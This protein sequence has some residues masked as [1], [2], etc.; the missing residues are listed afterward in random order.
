M[1]DPRLTVRLFGLRWGMRTSG[2]VVLAVAIGGVISRLVEIETEEASRGNGWLFVAAPTIAVLLLLL[3]GHEALKLQIWHRQGVVINRI[4]L[5]LFGGFSDLSG[6]AWTPRRE[7]TGA[8]TAFLALA[9]TATVLAGGAYLARNS[10]LWLRVPLKT[11]AIAAVGLAVLQTL[12]AL[13][14]DGGHVFHAWFWYLTDSA[15]AA[16]RAAAIYAHLVAASLIGMGVVLVSRTGPWPFWG[17]A[18]AFAGFQ[19]EGAARRA[20][21]RIH[22][23][24]LDTSATLR[25]V[26][27]P[28]P[29]K[30]PTTLSIDD[31]FDLLVT[32]PPDTCLLVTTPRGE[33]IGLLRLLDLRGTRRAQWDRLSV[34]EIARPLSEAISLP[35]DLSISMALSMLEERTGPAILTDSGQIVAALSREALLRAIAEHVPSR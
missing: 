26:L 3:A 28:T 22:W 15:P 5:C 2:L 8:I 18:A 33:P 19:V 31:A 29:I 21:Q 7:A 10:T 16:T 24:R 32:R 14:L 11:I 35:I 12:P 23:S 17:L 20:V 4:S 13:H 34:G 6:G 25:D 30:I 9:G 1:F 27:L